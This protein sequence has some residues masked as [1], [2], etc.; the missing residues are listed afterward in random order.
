MARR[1]KT[2]QICESYRPLLKKIKHLFPT[3]LGHVRTHRI[4]L[5][6]FQHRHSGFIAR[7]HRNRYPWCLAL[8]DYDYTIEFWCTRFE[9]KKEDYQLFVLL[10]ELRH[11]P[12]GG[13]DKE[14]PKTYR[15]LLHHDV[16]DFSDMLASYGLD[17]QHVDKIYKGEKH[18]LKTGVIQRFPRTTKMG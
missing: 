12:E 13:F 3:V 6:G 1:A 7:V 14:N 4:F 10:H 5:C 8:P 15:K 18:F 11:I 16:E 9:A 17:R 2:W